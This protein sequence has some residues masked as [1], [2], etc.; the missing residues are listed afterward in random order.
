MPD[1]I[2]Y[3]YHLF[4]KNIGTLGEVKLSPERDGINSPDGHLAE[5]GRVF[6]SPWPDSVIFRQKL[7][8]GRR[9]TMHEIQS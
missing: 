8:I 1:L 7:L 3:I 9:E 2:Y 6:L 5:R 4:I